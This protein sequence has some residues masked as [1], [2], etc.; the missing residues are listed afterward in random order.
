MKKEIK[1]Q[2]GRVY[3]RHVQDV[4]PLKQHVKQLRESHKESPTMGVHVGKIP[5]VAIIEYM[6][7]T[8]VSYHEFLNDDIHVKRI[9]MDSDYKDLRIWMGRF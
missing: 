1:A 3:T 4:E 2:D 7:R 5:K 6:S 8:G 9:L